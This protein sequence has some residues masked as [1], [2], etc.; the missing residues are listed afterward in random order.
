MSTS[1]PA[2][3]ASGDGIDSRLISRRRLLAGSSTLAAAA[4]MGSAAPVRNAQAQQPPA[5]AP[6]RTH[7]KK[8]QTKLGV[9]SSAHAIAQAQRLRPIP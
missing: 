3:H 7:L 1:G 5:A 8:A 2:N 4:A 9:H 6:V